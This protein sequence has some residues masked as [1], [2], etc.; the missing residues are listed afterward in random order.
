MS[1]S[2]KGY[3]ENVLTFNSKASKIGV[4]VRIDEDREVREASAENDFIGVTSSIDGKM[5][6]V[7]MDGYVELPYT[8][9]KPTYSYCYL[10]ANG[11]GGVKM[12]ASGTTSNHI[13]RVLTVDTENKIVG[14]IL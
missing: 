3:G 2:F 5:A 10:V 14:F 6:G 7:I 8:G 12:P 11:S 1:I 9:N 13:V 4:P